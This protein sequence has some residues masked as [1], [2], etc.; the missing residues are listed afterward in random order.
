MHRPDP[1]KWREK[2]PPIFFEVAS[3]S[4]AFEQTRTTIEAERVRQLEALGEG[5]S[6]AQRRAI[7][8]EAEI[9]HERV[10]AEVGRQL[11]QIQ[12]RHGDVPY[13]PL[14][15]SYLYPPG[16]T[17]EDEA[18]MLFREL[19][20]NR[21]QEA[22]HS[23][24]RR[25]VSGDLT[26]WNALSRTGADWRTLAFRKGPIEP[27]KVEMIHRHLLQLVMTWEKKPLTGDE[28]AACFDEHC[29]CGIQHSAD[30]LKK[31]FNRLKKDLRR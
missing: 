25:D 12:D 26:A 13:D 11:Q 9:K 4:C 29:P 21:H 23:T 1:D 15:S 17:Q 10:C 30:A 22:L 16:G 6:D 8:R 27:F 31:Q 24:F 2:L 18:M 19:H 7:C 20:W 28:R 14:P 3:L 5:A